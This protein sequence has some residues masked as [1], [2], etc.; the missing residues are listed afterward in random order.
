MVDVGGVGYEVATT[1]RGLGELPGL[2]EEVVVHTHLHVREDILDLYGFPTE[3][4]RDVFR[5]LLT[6]SGIGPK[7]ALAVCGSLTPGELRRAVMADDI[8]TLETVPGIGKRSAQKLIIELRPKLEL[9]N[10]E[11]PGAEGS[12]LSEVRQALDSL[13]YQTAEVKAAIAELPVEGSV[14]D[15]L[16]RALQSLGGEE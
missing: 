3:E 9:D 10:G 14:E 5:I 1:P 4:E 2:G 12:V 16:R 7:V 11:V 15:L 6:A 8:A 13:G